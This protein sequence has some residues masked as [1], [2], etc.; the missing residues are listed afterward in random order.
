M[1]SR[2]WRSCLGSFSWTGVALLLGGILRFSACWRINLGYHRLITHRSFFLPA[3]GRACIGHHR[4][5]LA[6]VRAAFWTAVHPPPHHFA[7]Q[8]PDHATPWPD[9]SGPDFG[10]PAGAARRHEARRADR[11][12]RSRRVARSA[13]RGAREEAR[14]GSRSLSPSGSCCSL[15]PAP[16]PQRTQAC[17]GVGPGL[18][19][20]GLGG[21]A[22]RTPSW[23]GTS[24]GRSVR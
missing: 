17:N 5:R 6:A 22:L 4:R 23:C 13:L 12:L 7:D 16:T 24:L 18:G 10:W 1:R 2:H 15:R 11:S 9:F 3:V 8:E 21:G 14:T 20:V 19:L